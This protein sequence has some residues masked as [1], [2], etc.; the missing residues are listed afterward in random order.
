[1]NRL[2]L[3]LLL[4]IVATAVGS[5]LL[6]VAG[7]D[8]S[9]L[10]SAEGVRWLFRLR[11][12]ESMVTRFEALLLVVVV[13]GAVI[14]SGLWDGLKAVLF[15]SNPS[16]MESE[17]AVIASLVASPDDMRIASA[18]KSAGASQTNSPER[19]PATLRQ[20]RALWL[21]LITVIVAMTLL[22]L[23]L[24]FPAS[25]LRSATGQVWPSPFLHGLMQVIALILV[26]TCAVYGATSR[27]LRSPADFAALLYHGIQ[28][29]APLLLIW[30]L[31]ELWVSMLRVL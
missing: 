20:R 17:G 30:Y 12:D 26:A 2:L 31:A 5:W 27:H 23:F 10:L 18:T 6:S 16:L 7:F 29:Y 28:R 15:P 14:R 9:N 22:F 8:V 4:L 24:C 11:P 25:P 21:S 3:S 13:T 1:M 19:R